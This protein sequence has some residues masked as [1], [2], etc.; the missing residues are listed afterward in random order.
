MGLMNV[1]RTPPEI[2]EEK[3]S[4]SEIQSPIFLRAST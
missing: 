3:S 4:R 1:T 2:P